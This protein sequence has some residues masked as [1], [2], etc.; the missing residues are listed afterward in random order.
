[1]RNSNRII[2]ITAAIVA[3]SFTHALSESVQQ[4]YQKHNDL[5][6]QG[7]ARAHQIAAHFVLPVS[8]KKLLTRKAL[9]ARSTSGKTKKVSS[10]TTSRHRK[11]RSLMGFVEGSACGLWK[12]IDSLAP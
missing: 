7:V 1:M 2:V 11:D 8:K 4:S 5:G 12:R 3:S 9:M 6:A 10:A